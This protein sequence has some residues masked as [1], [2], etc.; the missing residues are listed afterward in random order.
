MEGE[1]SGR[2]ALVTGGSRGIGRAIA[3]ALARAGADVA[4]NF[5]SRKA[6]ADEVCARIREMGRRSVAVQGNVASA[7][8]VERMVTEVRRELGAIRILVNNAGI[9][10]TRSLDEITEQDWDRIMEV[11]LKGAFLVTQAVLPD[12]RSAGWGRII[13]LSSVAAHMGG[14]VGLHYA[15]SKAG[16]IG[17]TH[18]YASHLVREGIT[19]NAIAPG[20]TDT[21]MVAALPQV[22]P[23]QIPVGRL[24]TVDEI[25]MVAVML[26]SNGFLTGQT[27][28]VNGGRYPA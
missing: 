19:A 1:L 11:N 8:D 13:S 10:Q 2:V 24:G 26:A 15:A 7:A 23:E 20:P 27:I 21:D 17:L 6:D 22:K 4:V 9:A 12:M 18:Y 25:A 3:L 14:S 5:R 16:I 28:N